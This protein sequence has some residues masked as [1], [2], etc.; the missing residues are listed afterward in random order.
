MGTM[1][2][3]LSVQMFVMLLFCNALYASCI[4]LLSEAVYAKELRQRPAHGPNMLSF[5]WGGMTIAGMLATLCS[6]LMLAHGSPWNLFSI[7]CVPA[8]FVLVPALMNWH[9]EQYITAEHLQKQRERLWQQKEALALACVMLI[10]TVV[11]SFSGLYLSDETNGIVSAIVVVVVLFCFTVLLNPT[12]AGVNAF[13]LIQ[14]CLGVST[15]GASFYFMMDDETQF[16][17]GPHFSI[18]FYNIILPLCGAVCSLFGIYVYQRT[19]GTWTYQRMYIIGNLVGSFL[20]LFDIIFFSRLNKQWGINDHV[21]VLGTSSLSSV[22]GE[23]L[24]MPSV[25]LLSQLCPRGMEAIMY[26]NLAGCHNIGN[27]VAQNF[28]AL[29]LKG[30]GVQPNGSANE[31]E[32][33]RHMW[34]VSLVGTIMPLLPVILVPWFIPNKLNNER[35]FDREDV[36]VNEGSLFR[37]WMGYE[38]REIDVA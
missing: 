16:P 26:A 37:R 7:A 34:C 13:G 20:A 22:I 38:D 5:V 14:T 10:S 33:F 28:T 36:Q 31:G 3:E 27:T 2:H 9:G 8:S 11:L 17:D 1:R 32:Q 18:T 35:V 29:L 30:F 15:G 4:D 25:V 12:I 21:F 24:W 23:W 19:A 6:G